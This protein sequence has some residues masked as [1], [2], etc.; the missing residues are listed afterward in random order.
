PLVGVLAGLSPAYVLRSRRRALALRLS[1]DLELAAS[2]EARS[3]PGAIR[4][5][6]AIPDEPVALVRAGGV[7]LSIGLGV[8]GWFGLPRAPAR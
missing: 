8:G 1:V 7:E 3:P 4:Y 6:D 2:M 5:V